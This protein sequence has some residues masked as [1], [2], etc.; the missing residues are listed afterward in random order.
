[1]EQTFVTIIS[2][3]KQ[4]AIF[5][6]SL[7][8]FIFANRPAASRPCL[9]VVRHLHLLLYLSATDATPIAAGTPL[10]KHGRHVASALVRCGRK[11]LSSLIHIHAVCPFFE[12]I[13]IS[14]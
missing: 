2:L 4:S 13:A 1:M 10:D 7:I 8:V 11:S 3:Q 6:L 9:V 12:K 14:A 5:C